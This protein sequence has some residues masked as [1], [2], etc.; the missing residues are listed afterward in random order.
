MFG[1]NSTGFGW[2]KKG[3]AQNLG[4]TIALNHYNRVTAAGGVLPCGVAALA[5]IINAICTAL[6][7]TTEAQFNAAVPEGLDPHYS[8]YLAGAGSGPTL[9]QA[10]QKIFNWA[11]A[12]GDVSQGTAGSMPLLLA[13]DGTNKYVFLPCISG[14]T[15][16]SGTA[17]TWT[18]ATDTLV[19][20]A[21]IFSNAQTSASWDSIGQQNTLFK[22]ELNSTG[23]TKAIRVSGS[24]SAAG[25][26]TYTP[27]STAPHWVRATITPANIT[28]EW[29]ADNTTW[30][31]LNS[32]VTLPTFGTT[33]TLT[34]GGTSVSTANAMSVYT[35]DFTNSTTAT[36]I[37]F[38]VSNYNAATS[39]TTLSTTGEVWTLN[40]GTASN[41]YKAC[42]V[43]KTIVMG[44]GVDDTLESASI[45]INQ[46]FTYSLANNPLG[47]TN[48]FYL[49]SSASGRIFIYQ[50]VTTNTS[51]G[52]PTDIDCGNIFP[53]NSLNFGSF[54]FNGA[55]GFSSK[56][57]AAITT[58]NY[59]TNNL[60][61]LSFLSGYLG[62]SQNCIINTLII[63]NIAED[64]TQRASMYNIIRQLN[65]NAF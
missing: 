34:I 5:S 58:R 47:T 59:G 23:A 16:T 51:A 27:S 30:T 37:S 63:T 2:G 18:P 40:V 49:D 15:V 19:L 45:T 35:F 44:D 31:T 26:S 56:N 55:S 21:K 53:S 52:G 29:S 25:S 33:G 22:L 60:S 50:N 8:G 65:N 28:Y 61:G 24:T 3:V 13:Y 64:I 62:A 39:Q 6:G 46:P 12:S 54:G 7:L 42:I 20:K 14:N 38:N 4:Q 36:T 1:H 17:V 43:S 32:G 41:G 57:N 11:G 10:C 48:A 9:G